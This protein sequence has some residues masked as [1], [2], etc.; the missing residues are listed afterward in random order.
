MPDVYPLSAPEPRG[1]LGYDGTH[2]YV[3]RV[4]DQGNLRLAPG[5]VNLRQFAAAYYERLSGAA[6][7]GSIT[8]NFTAVAAGRLLV[9]QTALGFLTAGTATSIA[10]AVTDGLTSYGIAR[11]ASPA[12]DVPGVFS[13]LVVLV[14]GMYVAI[15]AGGVGAGTTLIAAVVGYY[16]Q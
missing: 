4:D 16:V 3:V 11:V 8:L 5:G 1:M 6:G 2:Y 7:A 15:A 9:V 12:V 10:L 13:G 14:P